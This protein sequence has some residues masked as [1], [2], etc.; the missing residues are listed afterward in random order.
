MKRHDFT[1]GTDYTKTPKP[2]NRSNNDDAITRLT[3]V[4]ANGLKNMQKSNQALMEIIS[5]KHEN[6][7][8]Q[9]IPESIS[10]DPNESP[11]IQKASNNDLDEYNESV[12]QVKMSKLKSQQN[13]LLS[14]SQD[15]SRQLSKI[16]QEDKSENNDSAAN[17]NFLKVLYEKIN[18]NDTR[19]TKLI[20]RVE[21]LEI[22]NRNLNQKVE[23]IVIQNSEF[24]QQIEIEKL[25]TPSPSN[26]QEPDKTAPKPRRDIPVFDISPG[27]EPPPPPMNWANVAARG[28]KKNKKKQILEE[29]LIQNPDIVPTDDQNPEHKI[30]Y[31][32]EQN[33][34]ILDEL[35]ESAKTIGLRPLTQD[36]IDIETNRLPGSSHR[37]D[38]VTATK[39][40]VTQFL[41]RNL[42]MDKRMRNSIHITRI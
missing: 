30:T 35:E 8:L 41:K 23:G 32:E 16:N 5:E 3:E 24:K 37:D 22:N 13:R 1:T 28:L 31:T 27:D 34:Q 7:K 36:D 20:E 19:I 14:M 17:A 9:S 21:E 6:Q 26:R 25:R 15:M 29:V 4:M 39:N 42:K 12:S 40:L 38:Q 18:H 11:E 33:Q 10:D 2:P